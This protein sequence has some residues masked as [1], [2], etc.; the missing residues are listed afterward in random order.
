MWIPVDELK[1]GMKVGYPIL[2]EDGSILL[3]QGVALTPGY[4]KRLRELGFNSIFVED[5]LFADIKIE[6][7][8][9]I[10]TKRK[11]QK[12]L[13]ETVKKLQR[14]SKF[15][16]EKV[17][18]V[19]EE[20]ME[21]I[22][23]YPGTVF[24]LVQIR[25]CSDSIFSHS[26]S[27]GVISL[28]LGHYL[29]LDMDYLKKLGLGALL[30]DLGKIRF[31]PQ[32][33]EEREKITE[34]DKKLISLHPI[35]SREIIQMQPGY[36]FLVSLIALQ[37]HERMDGSGYP[38]GLIGEDIHFLSRICAC[39]DVYDALTVDRPYRKRFSYAEALE[40]LMGN[41]HSLFDL[42][43]VTTMVRHIAPYPVG[44]VVKLTSG[45][46]AVVI[47]LNE[48]LPI[49]PVVRVIKDEEGNTLSKPRDIDLMKELAISILCSGDETA[50]DFYP[51]SDISRFKEMDFI[52]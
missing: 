8:L 52:D 33:L 43:V 48:G 16:Y 26:V 10:E 45:E 28:L 37:H 49:R 13:F 25:Q 34:D 39:A 42:Q 31:P 21:E 35:W 47:K 18:K 14:G 15:S 32:L 17:A 40:Y 24:Y 2:R 3:N 1:P 50:E 12:V 44:E 19:L 20:V 4:I 27:V 38:Y 9:R 7:P 36:D 5:E 11:A 6:E 29:S 23:N 51:S 41:S 30:H 46:T 22:L